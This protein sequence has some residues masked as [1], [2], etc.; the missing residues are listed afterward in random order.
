M[1]PFAFIKGQLETMNCGQ[2]DPQQRKTG[3]C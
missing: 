3:L 1:N 2:K